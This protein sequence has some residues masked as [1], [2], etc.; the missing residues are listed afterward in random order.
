MS[1]SLIIYSP[2][3]WM[4]CSPSLSRGLPTSR[5]EEFRHEARQVHRLA[6]DLPH[7][8]QILL[9][10]ERPRPA[11]RRRRARVERPRRRAR[12]ISQ[13]VSVAEMSGVRPQPRPALMLESAGRR[14]TFERRCCSCEFGRIETAFYCRQS[15]ADS[16][17]TARAPTRDASRSAIFFIKAISMERVFC[18]Q[19]EQLAAVGDCAQA[20][21]R[22]LS[23]RM[24]N[25]R[26]N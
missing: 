21:P 1:K 15:L 5:P 3:R 20:V 24:S 10:Q 22:E 14:R 19:A 7:V 25:A 18:H 8:V 2:V 12:A 17:P 9:H 16:L 23:S 4:S 6:G 26:R 11:R 13:V